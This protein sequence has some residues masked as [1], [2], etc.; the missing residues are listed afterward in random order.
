MAD[1]RTIVVKGSGTVSQSPD[2][3]GISFDVRGHEMDYT[4]S[5]KS[6]NRK[7]E[8]VRLAVEEA[9]V[10]R[11]ALKTTSFRIKADTV[12]DKKT[13]EYNFNG[14]IAT[15]KLKLEFPRDTE[16]SNRLLKAIA[17]KVSS[18]DFD[19]Y[20][21]VSDPQALKDRLVEDAVKNARRKA[22]LMTKAAG[23]K[24]GKI[25]RINYSWS[26]VHFHSR[27]TE[28]L[29]CEAMVDIEAQPD[30]EPEDIEKTDNVEVVWEIVD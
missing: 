13:E 17:E 5:L 27:M 24:L 29:C 28:N 30:F 6:L 21:T 22:D 7:V 10:D 23:V 4:D 15:H 8:E 26:E 20:F 25:L 2:V 11:K 14:Y 12:Y 3:F 19:I 18:A 16:K 1:T 9:G